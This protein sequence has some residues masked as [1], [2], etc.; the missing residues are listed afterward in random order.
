VARN[1]RQRTAR[2]YPRA[3]TRRRT[4]SWTGQGQVRPA[5]GRGDAGSGA[6][7][8]DTETWP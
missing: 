2:P 5:W 1:P 3:G 6:L 4:R 8:H 7:G